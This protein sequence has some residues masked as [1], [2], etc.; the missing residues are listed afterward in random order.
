M[1]KPVQVK[2]CGIKRVED[3]GM[4]AEA[5][6][7]AIGV[8][9]GQRHPSGDFMNLEAARDIFMTPLP[10][11]LKV[12]VTHL[13]RLEELAPLIE[14]LQPDVAQLHSSISPDEM[15]RLR[16]HF[17]TLKLWRALHV[18]DQSG[19]ESGRPFIG[20][21]DGFVLDSFNPA[22]GQ[23]GGT[24]QVND[25][26]LSRQMVAKYEIPCWLAGGLHPGNVAAAVREVHPFGVDA[27]TGTKA[28]DG[29][30]DE[31]KVRMFMEQAKLHFS[32]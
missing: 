15:G 6:A 23:V 4:A 12:M 16:R 5:G 13:K 2:I 30:K 8:L 28:P 26:T 31:L 18:P 29:F 32:T 10:H 17:P 27:N 7:D 9:V 11:V 21:A 14:E 1:T 25:W 22:T 20:M 3:A 19:L 24:G